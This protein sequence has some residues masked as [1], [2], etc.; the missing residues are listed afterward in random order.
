MSEFAKTLA[1]ITQFSFPTTRALVE[2]RFDPLRCETAKLEAEFAR[3][4]DAIPIPLELIK[5]AEVKANQADAVLR[6]LLA[7]RNDA[8]KAVSNI[9]PQQL[10]TGQL[11]SVQ[12]TIKQI[13]ARFADIDCVAIETAIIEWEAFYK[14]PS[15]DVERLKNDLHKLTTTGGKDLQYSEII[16]L[17]E[18]LTLL[19]TEI[20]QKQ[21]T[22]SETYQGTE[23]NELAAPIVASLCDRV[24]QLE[25]QLQMIRMQTKQQMKQH[26]KKRVDNI[27]T[28]IFWIFVGACG[29]STGIW[30][31]SSGEVWDTANMQLGVG[32][33][34]LIF[35]GLGGWG[36]IAGINYL[37]LNRKL[38]ISPESSSVTPTVPTTVVGD[39]EPDSGKKDA[40]EIITPIRGID[41]LELEKSEAQWASF[42]GDF[43]T[44]LKRIRQEIADLKP[45]SE[46]FVL[47]KLWRF[48]R[49]ANL[50]SADVERMHQDLCCH[51]A[52][53]EQDYY[54][55]TP[56][57]TFANARCD[58]AQLQLRL[59][60]DEID[61]YK[62]LNVVRLTT[63]LVNAV[64]IVFVFLLLLNKSALVTNSVVRS[65]K[66]VLSSRKQFGYGI[67]LLLAYSCWH[68]DQWLVVLMLRLAAKRGNAEAP[69][70]LAE[71]YASGIMVE[72]SEAREL[73]W[74]RKAAEA[75]H[76]NARFHLGIMYR[77]GK[78]VQRDF[79][80]AARWFRAAADQGF[81]PAQ[82]NLGVMYSEGEVVS[83]DSSEA[84][85][86][87]FAAARQGLAVAQFAV[88]AGYANGKGDATAVEAANWFRKAAEQ[89][90]A[91][92]QFNLA[93]MYYNG[94]GIKQD[95]TEALK[96][97][98][99][100]ADQG[101]VNALEFVKTLQRL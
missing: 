88:G 51:R 50:L 78:Q 70:L 28:G 27:A 38:A 32:G 10:G 56:F 36:V 96:W 72:K 80:A 93:M 16:G 13:K 7:E 54:R 64:V 81:A 1:D 58:C 8:A 77:D 31:M 23:F 82:H 101:H 24:R 39:D 9:L 87:F 20:T 74:C 42:S 65:I 92:A 76:P 89:G 30:M 99:K 57:Y 11:R 35:L 100:A 21:Q 49:K 66:S 84:M 75:E 18:R 37:R 67:L 68:L 12:Q 6:A 17:D 60:R 52:A 4:F 91:E 90:L 40:N 25:L 47:W 85:K 26:G 45:L 62:C 95:H 79:A 48:L 34:G 61:C 44:A 41:F 43:D 3:V 55:G 14:N 71:M 73:W 2:Q 5:S 97:F 33:L 29:L 19:R 98:R 69:W 22:L 83:Q 86:W 94:G 15:V 53:L 59:N 46:W 63:T